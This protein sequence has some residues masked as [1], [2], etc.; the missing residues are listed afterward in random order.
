MHPGTS[1]IYLGFY[2]GTVEIMNVD[3]GA[4]SVYKIKAQ[5]V[6]L[7]SDNSKGYACNKLKK[8]HK[9]THIVLYID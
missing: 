6:G 1:Y 2:D 9:L 5:D 4:V 7:E 3:S 8:G